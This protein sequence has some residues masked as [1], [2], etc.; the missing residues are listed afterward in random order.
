MD[1]TQPTQA[2]QKIQIIFEFLTNSAIDSP[3]HPKNPSH[4]GRINPN[5]R[6]IP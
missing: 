1:K 4:S 3:F 5:P 6:S 2:D